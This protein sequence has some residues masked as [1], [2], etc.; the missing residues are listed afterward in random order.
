MA[1]IDTR[2][3]SCPQPVLMTKKALEVNSSEVTVL[4]DSKTAKSNVERYLNLTGY[5]I[6]TIQLDGETNTFEISAKKK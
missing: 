5:T 3:M 4:V 6:D 2:G 1:Q